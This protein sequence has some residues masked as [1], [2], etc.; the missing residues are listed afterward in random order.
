M[1]LIGAARWLRTR[2]NGLL[3]HHRAEHDVT[4][5]SSR[6]GGLEDT[7]VPLVAANLADIVQH[8]RRDDQFRV[9]PCD[10]CHRGADPDNLGGVLEETA[11]CRVVTDT[12]RARALFVR[13]TEIVVGVEQVEQRPQAWSADSGTSLIEVLPVPVDVAH[14]RHEIGERHAAPG[15]RPDRDRLELSGLAIARDL[16]HDLYEHSLGQA[17]HHLV[18]PRPEGCGIDS[19]GPVAEHQDGARVIA[20]S[21][22]DV[23]QEQRVVHIG[24][25][26]ERLEVEHVA[27]SSPALYLR[28]MRPLHVLL[29]VTDPAREDAVALRDA[30]REAGHVTVENSSTPIPAAVPQAPDFVVTEGAA[31]P[32]PESLDAAIGRHIAAVLRHTN[33]NKRQAALLLGVARSTLL[34][35]IRRHG[36]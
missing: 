35:R 22:H 5:H 19:A 4:D 9:G 10:P 27:Q 30:L 8:R 25:D 31:M 16:A 12:G 13:E 34:A 18:A 32:V 3:Q 33:G 23:E 21:Y 11:Q 17:A 7:G 6:F 15:E 24:A 20:R 36:L 14:A 29:L 1:Q 2:R 26:G 28:S